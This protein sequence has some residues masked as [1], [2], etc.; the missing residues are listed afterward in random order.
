MAKNGTKG[1]TASAPASVNP[2]PRSRRILIVEDEKSI[3]EL[4]LQVI[5]YGLPK[6]RVDVAVNGEEAVEEF[7]EARHDVLLMDL[8]MPIMDGEQAFY[9]IEKICKAENW[10]MPSVVFC[11]GYAPSEVIRTLVAGNPAHCLLR[12]PVSSEQLMEAILSRL[13]PA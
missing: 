5:S 2:P 10:P 4:F 12:K 8:K 9:E 3:R 7:R 6:C 11:S 13:P 1:K